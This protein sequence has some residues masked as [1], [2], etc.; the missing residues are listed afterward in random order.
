[1]EGWKGMEDKTSVENVLKAEKGNA[2]NTTQ[3]K[4]K[5]KKERR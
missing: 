4:Y 2:K 3:E 1:M 5:N